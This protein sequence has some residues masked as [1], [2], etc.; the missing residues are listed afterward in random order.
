[1]QRALCICALVPRLP[2]ETHVVLVLHQ[3]ETKKTTN[4]G[5]LATRCLPKSSVVMRG[6]GEPV[7]GERLWPEGFAPI[8]LYPSDDSVP[9]RSYRSESSRP[10]ALI[11]LDGTWS[12]AARARRRTAALAGVP[13]VHLD[14]AAPSAYRL[15]TPTRPGRVSTLEAIARALEILE[16]PR[17]PAI[18]GA[19]ERIQR[20]MVERT[21]WSSGK[22]AAAEVEGGIPGGVRMDRAW[23]HP[24]PRRVLF[25]CTGNYYRSRFAE[26]LFNHL[27]AA[28][29]PE[30]D[31]IAIA[32]SAGLVEHCAGRNPGPLSP[33][34]VRGLAARGIAVEGA[35][36]GPRDVTPNDLAGADVVVAVKESEHRPMVEARFAPFASRIVYWNIDDVEDAP[37]EIALAALE[38]RVRDLVSALQNSRA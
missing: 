17:G 29:A 8:L 10:A 2:T 4:T 3:L 26:L 28:L 25:L 36:R 16:G 27:T 11:V 12:Q 38:T 9:V 21:L 33:H 20:I 35:P 13:S 7:S 19:L 30:G 1:M 23:E 14:D 31:F 15:R 22:L 34:T 32:D 5:L 24:G 6:G 37:P 18:R